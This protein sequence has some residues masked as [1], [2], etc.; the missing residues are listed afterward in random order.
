MQRNH[1]WDAKAALA[2]IHALVAIK[3]GGGIESWRDYG[4]VLLA[5]RQLM[6]NKKEFGDWIVKYKLNS[7]PASNAPDR[8]NSMWIAARWAD[9]VPVLDRLHH[10]TPSRLRQECRELGY[11]WAFA[12]EQANADGTRST[13]AASMPSGIRPP[14]GSAGPNA[15]APKAQVPRMRQPR[16]LAPRSKRESGMARSELGA[17]ARATDSRMQKRPHVMLS[18]DERRRR[19]RQL[20]PD[21]LGR[22]QTEAEAA[23]YRKLTVKAAARKSTSA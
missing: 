1:H 3:R 4:A 23:E 17:N 12:R 7:D 15:A 6:V 2:A 10:R 9:L 13:G 20:H 18:P 11:S 16:P 8:S 5:Q 22:A 14:V 19:L 21:I